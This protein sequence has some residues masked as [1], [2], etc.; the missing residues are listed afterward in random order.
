[1]EPAINADLT[2]NLQSPDDLTLELLRDLGW[3]PDAD[4]D[5]LADQLDCDP[6]SDLSATL[7]IA[8]CDSG[9]T[10]FSFTSGCTFSDLIQQIGANSRNHG[11][12][13]SGVAHLTNA[14]KSAGLISGN[15]K[16]VIQRCAAGA[17]IP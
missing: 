2:H 4:L 15:Q 7:V 13:E 8:G 1:M 16:S 11:Q 5:G 6:T 9:V 10:N 3:F 17:N 12:F 14:L